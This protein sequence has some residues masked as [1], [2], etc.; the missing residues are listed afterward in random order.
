MGL[1]SKAWK[2]TKS[3]VKDPINVIAPFAGGAKGL[4][5]GA[6]IGLGGKFGISG[7][8]IF[9]AGV[10]YFSQQGQNQANARQVANQMRFQERM[11]STAI[12]RARADMMAAGINPILAGT[13]PASSPGGASAQMGN[14]GYQ[15]LTAAQQNRSLR[16]QLKLQGNQANLVGENIELV[17]A[18]EKIAQA[19]A[20]SVEQ[21]N[22]IRKH[23]VNMYDSLA[24]APFWVK[25]LI[26]VVGAASALLAWSRSKKPGKKGNKPKGTDNPPPIGWK[27]KTGK[28]QNPY[29][30]GN[31]RLRQQNWRNQRKGFTTDHL[32][33]EGFK[34]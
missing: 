32:Y 3:F 15:A 7:G 10:G 34:R 18:Q 9:N 30:P 29:A 13:N 22:E 4:A 8:D 31:E 17:K 19:N 11:S 2:K 28:T 20:T 5:T 26:P 1:L 27:N 14:S 23:E 12:Q 24:G 25:A 6:A 16:A 21:Q 33:P